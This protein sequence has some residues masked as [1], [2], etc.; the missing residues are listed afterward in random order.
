MKIS[1]LIVTQASVRKPENI[2]KMQYWLSQKKKFDLS[3]VGKPENLIYLARIYNQYCDKYCY[4]VHDGHHRLL[5]KV[6]TNHLELCES[7]YQIVEWKAEDYD[8]VDF[9]LGYITPFDIINEVRKPNLYEFKKQVYDL[10]V[11]LRM[12]YIEKN[13]HIYCEK[14]NDLITVYDLSEKMFG[15]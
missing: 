15:I 4:F 3:F 8:R 1:D 11:Q 14:R 10:P 6:L 2:L 9:D 13:R 12:D 5:A 7:E